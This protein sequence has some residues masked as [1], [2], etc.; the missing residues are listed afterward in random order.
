MWNP[1]SEEVRLSDVGV[2]ADGATDNAPMLFALREALR[3]QPERHYR[4]ICPPGEIRSSD[5]R[6]LMGLK[7]FALVGYGTKLVSTDQSSNSAAKNPVCGGDI[8]ITN[9]YASQSALTLAG[10]VRFHSARAGSYGVSLV[11]AADAAGLVP[12]KKVFLGGYDQMASGYPPNWRYFEWK[13]IESADAETGD[14]SFTGPLFNSYDEQWHDAPG[15]LGEGKASGKPRMV[16]IDRDPTTVS[17][18]DRAEFYGLTMGLSTVADGSGFRGAFHFP[19]RFLSA[20]DVTVEGHVWPSQNEVAEYIDCDIGQ[21]DLDKLCDIV[22][23]IRPRFRGGVYAATG[24]NHL[25]LAGGSAKGVVSVAPRRLT[26]RGGF[27]FGTNDNNPSLGPYPAHYPIETIRL[28][29]ARLAAGPA[30]TAPQ[31]I[32]FLGKRAFTISATSGSDILFPFGTFADDDPIWGVVRVLDI[33][34]ILQKSDASKSGVIS[35]I[36]FDDA[37]S[38]WEVAGSWAAPIEGETWNYWPV[39][40]IAVDRVEV[41]DDLPLADSGSAAL[42]I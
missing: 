27:T 34:G 7:N 30:A 16:L 14:V 36:R 38:R 18:A 1:R 8:F 39:R 15:I 40:Q 17:Y 41:L 11:E 22:T 20:W 3:Q 32:Q 19:A 31:H 37:N 42:V 35:S 12:G 2:K 6:W 9:P 33:G 5:T 29:G 26:L 10:G 28:G 13:T 23:F 25:T 4:I 21:T 24:I